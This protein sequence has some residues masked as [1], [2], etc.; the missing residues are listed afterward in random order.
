MEATKQQ[1]ASIF[2]GH[3]VL[4][5][6]FYQRS[7]VWK[8]E[9]WQRFLEDM[10]F[11]THC[12]QDYFLGSVIL[13]QQMTDMGESNDHRTIIDGQQRFTT[14]ALFAKS[15]CLKTNDIDTFNQHFTVRNKKKG[16][17][18]LALIHSLNDR[19]DFEKI[20][21]L[22]EDVP[23]EDAHSNILNCY[24]FFQ[25]NIN[26]EKLDIDTLMAH[27]VFIAIELQQQDDEQV[28]FDTI[29]S[30][31]VRLTT[32]E[33][34]KNYFFT[35][36]HREEYEQFWMPIFEKDREVINYWDATVSA[37]RM[38]RSNI[39]AF[40][41]AFLNIKIHDPKIGVD[42]EHKII[43]RRAEAIFSNYKDLIITYGLDKKELLWEIMEYADIYKSNINPNIDNIELPG[44]PCIERINFLITVLDNSTLLPYVLYILHNVKSI[45][46]RN[47]IFGYLESYIVR[48]QLCKSEN[49]SY[50]DL[51]SENL[52]GNQILTLEALK[53]YIENKGEIQALS[54]P[55]DDKVRECLQD[56]DH[57]NKR[58]LA[59]LY[60]METRLRSDRPHATKLYAFEE[61]S[62]EHLMP[63][64][65]EKNW[66][67]HDGFDED[68]RRFLI[69]T[70][71]NMAMLPQ[72]LNSSISN[73]PWEVK[74]E[75]NKKQSGLIYYASD[76]VTLK[77]VI[78]KKEW[79]EETIK[80]RSEWLGDVAVK[81][82]PSYLPGQE[83]G[84]EIEMDDS[85]EV[86]FENK[87]PIVEQ[88]KSRRNMNH[89]LTKYSL[90]GSP[91]MS[92]SE[93]VPVLVRTYVE[94]HSDMTYKQLKA[95]FKDSLCAP[96]FKFKGFLCSE[97]EYNDWDN[98]LKEK[99]YQPNKPLR[100][101]ISADD[102]AFFVN[103]QWTQE[104]LKRIV[105]LAKDEGMIVETKN[106]L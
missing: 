18:S 5:V 79:N 96:G 73:A 31:G 71:G 36:A 51:F 39:D 80:E 88:Q 93:F 54:L 55:N 11:I 47:L 9:Q 23:I 38:R 60:L 2:N 101:L 74:K 78:K 42:A 8:I 43:Y 65:Y 21:A 82:W 50:S 104:S 85:N 57:P 83:E 100:R 20:L 16:T 103:T 3:R 77:N 44:R 1:I 87:V 97:K 106:K 45:S 4:E 102:I 81:I 33:L 30:L 89:D 52:V 68:T 14:L 91:F 26:I 19:A 99:R 7:Y 58:G 92:K 12:N 32:A 29:N 28:I 53:D 56:V 70:L 49:N 86:P 69:N 35:E 62:L 72:R 66:P 24:N 59:I 17:K 10:E 27:I 13:K 46:E 22:E 15:L 94:K 95:I 76:L 48:R 67:L 63:K 34:L 37:G 41:A 84:I 105:K 75:G 98:P 6:P 64:K 40:F 61:Y 25:E 90:N